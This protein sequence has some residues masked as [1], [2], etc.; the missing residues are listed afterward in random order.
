M[1]PYITIGS[2]IHFAGN[3]WTVA[4]LTKRG[5]TLSVVVD[6]RSFTRQV[7]LRQL[8]AALPQKGR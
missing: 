4:K 5:A 6:G 3:R 8:E 7:P 1:K 2:P